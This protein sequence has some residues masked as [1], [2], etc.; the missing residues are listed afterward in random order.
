M[1]FGKQP[2]GNMLFRAVSVF[3]AILVIWVSCVCGVTGG[4]GNAKSLAVGLNN[5]RVI[6][7]TMLC[8]SRLSLTVSGANLLLE[9]LSEPSIKYKCSAAGSG[10]CFCFRR[11]HQDNQGWKYYG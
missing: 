11:L 7:L 3:W 2:G 6:D 5:L 10:K 4:L 1:D 8:S 9:G